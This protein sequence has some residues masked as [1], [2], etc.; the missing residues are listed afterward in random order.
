MI[1]VGVGAVESTVTVLRSSFV[2][3]AASKITAW[4]S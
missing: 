3:P 1:A 4:A 2:F